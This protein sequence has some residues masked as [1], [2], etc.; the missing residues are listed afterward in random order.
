LP[1]TSHNYPAARLIE[2]FGDVGIVPDRGFQSEP[3]QIIKTR[4]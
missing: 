4:S 3:C 2:Q 1:K